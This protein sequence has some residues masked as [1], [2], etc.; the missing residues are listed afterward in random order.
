MLNKKIKSITH[1]AIVIIST[2]L[3]S[4]LIYREY[5]T[6]QNY[7]EYVAENGKSA[8]FHEQY[9]NQRIAF[10]LSTLFSRPAALDTRDAT[11]TCRQ[12]EHVNGIY[13]LNLIDRQFAALPGTLQS[14]DANCQR[15]VKDAWAVI[16]LD[17]DIFTTSNK[18]SFS[19]YGGYIFD[20]IRY[21]IDLENNYAYSSKVIDIQKH[22][23]PYWENE[24]TP[25]IS[26][27]KYAHGIG[28]NDVE[29]DDFLKGSCITSHIHNDEVVNNKVFSLVA[30]VFNS[31]KIKGMV[32][33]DINADDLA[34][35]FYTTSR[36]TLWSA[37]QLWVSDTG[38]GYSIAFQTP[39]L[40]IAPLLSVSARLTDALTLHIRVDI[41]YFLL[42]NLWLIALYLLTCLL[43]LRY[44]SHQLNRHATLSRD[45][46]T[47][48]LTG[49][50]N[51]KLLSERMKQKIAALLRH[52]IAVTVIA[53]DCDDLKQI[54]D[55]LGHQAGDRAIALLGKAIARSVRKSDYGIRIGG[56]EF[57]MILIDA[58]EGK[59]AEVVHRVAEKLTETDGEQRVLFSWGCYQLQRN[60][61][62]DA[63]F[64]AADKRLYQQKRLKKT[65]RRSGPPAEQR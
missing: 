44:A 53:I 59:A 41:W 12:Q 8:L 25:A 24:S 14:R 4:G 56:D 29:V 16:S 2:I 61:S 40:S 65:G 26:L 1:A 54:N 64:I 9:I 38:S 57:V 43:L 22:P 28:V 35:A 46:V 5:L 49:L 23:F 33:T 11:S 6:L 30:P 10:R 31:G 52:Q 60:D 15:W 18:Y 47:D 34:T 45:N 36:P 17:D 42:S 63:A 37:M 21:Y 39:G 20:N 7:M 55:V 48:A 3:F 32:V 27:R 50:Y 19:N 62:L 58:D 13:G 51:R